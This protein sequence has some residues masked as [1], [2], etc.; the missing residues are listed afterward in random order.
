MAKLILNEETYVPEFQGDIEF[1][2]EPL[3]YDQVNGRMVR[4][5]SFLW[6]VEAPQHIKADYSN[7]Y[8]IAGEKLK[9]DFIKFAKSLQV[10]VKNNVK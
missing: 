7:I 4:K 3:W 5:I 1:T 8:E 9:Q 6:D 10:S 2:V